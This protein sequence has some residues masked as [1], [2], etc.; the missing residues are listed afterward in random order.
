MA[1]IRCAKG[2]YYDDVKFSQC[3]HCGVFADDD[4]T[5]ALK[6]SSAPAADSDDKTVAMRPVAQARPPVT[7]DDKTVGV[8]AQ[9]KGT[10]FIAG[11]LV[12]VKGPEKG[13][14]YRLYHGFSRIGRDYKLD[15]PVMEDPSIA[16]ESNCAVVYD[17]RGNQFYAVQ[18]AGATAYLNGMLLEEPTPIKTGDVI[19]I[20][21]SEFE[22]VAFCREGRVWERD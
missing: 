7:D 4:K 9:E 6:P 2:H 19:G 1:V 15:V 5:V 12:C 13:R 3:P 14:D 18:Q 17:G 20:G 11:W 21:S 16:R 8:Y 10:D 22:F